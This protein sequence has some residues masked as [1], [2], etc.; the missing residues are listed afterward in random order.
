[1]IHNI[2]KLRGVAALMVFFHHALGHFLAMG[3]SFPLFEWLARVGFLG[4]DV[5]FVISGLVIAK[6]LDKQP[7]ATL[8]FKKRFFRIFL[9]YWPM[10]A[11]AWVVHAFYHPERLPHI[12]LLGSFTL[13]SLKMDSLLI[14]PSW[15]LTY[16]LFFYLL[17]GV[18]LLLTV[19]KPM[20]WMFL[21]SIA[22]IIKINTIKYHLYP[23]LDFLM[24]PMVL[25]FFAGF[26]LWRQR[27]ALTQS[28]M[29]FYGVLVLGILG[30]LVGVHQE[31]HNAGLRVISFGVFSFALVYLALTT[32]SKNQNKKPSL[33]VKLGD[34]SY[35]LYLFHTILL[36]WF[37]SVG[38]RDWL[39]QGS[40]AWI[41][42]SLMILGTLV[43]SHLLYLTIEKPLYQWAINYKSKELTTHH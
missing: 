28:R 12:D 31:W 43:I 4:V 15:S 37:Y 11:L 36:G 30:L 6:S 25:E 23:L 2:Q 8:F 42:F 18:L 3:L 32:E 5:F 35:T 19:T 26:V 21:H 13:M 29:L 17:V 40:L 9:G 22:I 20:F 41:G 27:T 10:F 16:E 14:F 38:L 24:S 1:M 34:S 39:T 33:F 7:K